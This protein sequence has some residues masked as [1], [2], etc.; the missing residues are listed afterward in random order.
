M[1]TRRWGIGVV[2]LVVL[3]VGGWLY[4]T[5]TRSAPPQPV[6]V[7]P[8]E[9]TTRILFIGEENGVTGK[10]RLPHDQDG[11]TSCLLK[12]LEHGYSSHFQSDSRFGAR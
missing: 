12:I 9:P 10:G 1:K 4:F 7:M 8:P 6:I 5:R 11:L 2:L 3:A